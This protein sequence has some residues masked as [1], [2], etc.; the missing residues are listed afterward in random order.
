[1]IGARTMKKTGEKELNEMTKEE[2]WALFPIFLVAPNPQWEETYLAEKARI[3][4]VVGKEKIARIEHIGST[5][6]GGIWAKNIVD[7]LLETENVDGLQAVKDALT[8]NGYLCMYEESNRVG[9]NRGYT[10]RGFARDVFHLHIRLR[11]DHDEIFFRDYLRA[12][13]SVAKEYET[14]KLSLW[15]RFE[16]DRDGYTD[17]KTAFI[18]K[19]TAI[20]K[21]DGKENP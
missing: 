12:H 13:P 20:A 19:Y 17:A 1:M 6:I 4:R 10:K 7:I 21:R 15:K 2:L 8:A 5:A 14:L 11:G 9:L 16:H 3:E 18:E